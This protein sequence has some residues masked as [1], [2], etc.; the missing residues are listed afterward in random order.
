MPLVSFQQNYCQFHNQLITDRGL[1]LMPECQNSRSMLRLSQKI[2]LGNPPVARGGF[3]P[4][5]L[6]PSLADS[7]CLASSA[8]P[9]SFHSLDTHSQT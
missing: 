7:P 4:P 3:L 5:T 8:R 6:P 2:L 9:T 1:S